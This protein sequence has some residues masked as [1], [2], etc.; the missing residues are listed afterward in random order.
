MNGPTWERLWLW[1]PSFHLL[2]GPQGS[3]GSRPASPAWNSHSNTYSSMSQGVLTLF[4]PVSP[5]LEFNSNLNLSL[6]LMQRYEHFDQGSFS[7]SSSM[8]SVDSLIMNMGTHV[9]ETSKR[10]KFPLS[11]R[12]TAP[13]SGSNL[14]FSPS[15]QFLLGLSKA[16]RDVVFAR[17]TIIN[18][19][20]RSKEWRNWSRE[21]T[22]T[23]SYRRLFP[24]R[25]PSAPEIL[26]C[27][28]ENLSCGRVKHPFLRSLMGRGM[29]LISIWEDTVPAVRN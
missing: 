20:I 18:A 2:R 8:R 23:L 15:S 6:A 13:V 29:V 5:T 27:N 28:Q 26:T 1:L 22:Q 24:R 14:P 10:S 11:F 19:L 16:I 25:F 3:L 9:S 17:L 4:E 21:E 7:S 12:W